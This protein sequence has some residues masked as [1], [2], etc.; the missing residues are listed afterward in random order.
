MSAFYIGRGEF[1]GGSC[2]EDQD[3]EE[4]VLKSDVK[5]L[6]LGDCTRMM[7][8]MMM[9]ILNSSLLEHVRNTVGSLLA[10]V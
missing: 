3:E 4:E 10:H 6:C 9:R 7:R 5:L 8:M 2:R 1:E